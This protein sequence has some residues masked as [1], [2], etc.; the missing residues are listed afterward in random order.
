MDMPN[1][2]GAVDLGVL[3]PLVKGSRDQR[4]FPAFKQRACFV[5]GQLELSSREQNWARS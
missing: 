3:V 5:K 1:D 2:I 4:L